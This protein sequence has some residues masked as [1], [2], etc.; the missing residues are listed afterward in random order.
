MNQIQKKTMVDNH[1]SCPLCSSQSAF[2]CNCQGRV[3]YICE[4]CDLVFVSPSDRLTPKGEKN[5]YLEHNNN[6]EDKGYQR[7]LY[8]VV[9]TVLLNHES[10]AAG[11]DYGCGTGSPLP[12]MLR[13]HGFYMDVYD[14]FFAP[15]KEV[16]GKKYDFITCTEVVEHMRC[17]GED[18]FTL[19]SM[20]KPGGGL[21]IK[22]QFRIPSCDFSNW[23]YIRDL[24]HIVL[25]SEK[26]MKWLAKTLS[27]HLSFPGN[28]VAVLR[29]NF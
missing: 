23:H 4:T 2:F 15:H 17:P 3:F 20:L 5:R 6:P 24:T 10:P 22:T 29:K 19:W 28:N 7:F 25:Y 12:G 27:A 1:Q 26:T 16:F 8:P 9:E 18:I 13:E 21:F 11:L 14:P